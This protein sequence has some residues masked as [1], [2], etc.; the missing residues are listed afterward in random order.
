M[1]LAN[2]EPETHKIEFRSGKKDYHFVV[3][4][5]HTDDITYIVGNHLADIQAGITLFEE[6]RTSSDRTVEAKMDAF[7]LTV[8]RE[9]PALVAEII[10]V[11]ADE[12]ELLEKYVKLPFS[13]QATAMAEVTRMTFEDGGGLKNLSATTANLILQ[14]LPESAREVLRLHL[15]E[16]QQNDTIGASAK[17]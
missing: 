10:S 12:R 16:L 7:I 17:T 9:A 8:C 2:Y 11:A 14:M 3:R 1:G 4:G 5:L 15:P 13:V 6:A